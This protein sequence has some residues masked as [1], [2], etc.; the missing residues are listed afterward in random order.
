LPAQIG[1]TGMDVLASIKATVDPNGVMN[2][3]A[4][5]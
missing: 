1:D 5:L 4:L 2:P 3:G